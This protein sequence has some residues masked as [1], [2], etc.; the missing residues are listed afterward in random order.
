MKRSEIWLITLD[1]T[2]G[3]EIRKT[4]PA[5]VVSDDTF[6]K[7]PLKVIVPLT[8]WENRY[9]E[10]DWMVKIENNQ[11]NGLTKT[12]SADCLQVKSV[13]TKRFIKKLG[14]LS[15]SKM[16]SVEIAL[17]NVLKIKTDHKK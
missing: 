4:R 9:T 17:S 7:L 6:G 12:S 13:S 11:T 3:A 14:D 5:I 15:P 2:V 10:A 16:R 8:G 1:P